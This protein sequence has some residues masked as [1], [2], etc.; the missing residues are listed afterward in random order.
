LTERRIK[1]AHKHTQQLVRKYRQGLS[2]ASQERQQILNFRL[3]NLEKTLARYSKTLK[4]SSAKVARKTE[5]KEHHS[6]TGQ[7]KMRLNRRGTSA[8]D[9]RYMERNNIFPMRKEEPHITAK[10]AA[11]RRKKKRAH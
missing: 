4:A 7:P 9:F 6:L 2:K 3:G 8:Q 1:I 10:K 5:G 11:P